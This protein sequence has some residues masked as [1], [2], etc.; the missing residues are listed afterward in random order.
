MLNM[1][2]MRFVGVICTILVIL[3]PQQAQSEAFPADFTADTIISLN[4]LPVTAIKYGEGFNNKAIASTTIGKTEIERYRINSFKD[5]SA[6]IPNFY[7]PDYGSRMTS[8]IYVRGQGTRIDQPVVG[9]NI[10]NIPVLTKENYDL[11]LLDIERIEMLRG[12]QSALF[13]R[14]TM[15][16]V[17]NI[18]TLSPFNYQGTRAVLSYS[19]GNTYRI[20]LSTYQLINDR[21]GLSVAAGY[22]STDGFFDNNY[23]GCDLDWEKHGEG[24]AKLQWQAKEDLR[25]DNVFSFSIS[26]QGGYPYESAERGEINYND[27]CFYRRANI[28]DGITLELTRDRYTMTSITSYQY[29]DDNMT[30]DQ[31]FLPLSYF[32]LTQ[33]RREHTLTH[34]VMFKSP[35]ENSSPYS[36]L[37]GFFGFYKH[38]KMDAPV[39]FKDDGITNLIEYYRNLYNSDYPV[40]WDTRE[41]LLNSNFKTNNFGLALYH[42]S[43]YKL[44]RWTFTAALRLDFEY[45]RLDYLSQCNTGYNTYAPDGS[46]YRHDD[47]NINDPGNETKTFLQLLPKISASYDFDTPQPISVFASVGKGYKAGGFNTQMFSDVLQQRLMNYMGIGSNYKVEDIISYK[48]ETNWNI[49]AGVHAECFDGRI[50]TD[51]SLFY[52]HTTNQQLTMFPD[53][54][55]TGRIM[56]NAGKS[57]SYGAEIAIKANPIDPL[58]VSVSYGFT[59]ARF[60]EFNNG[61]ENYSGNFI[62]YAPQNTIFA[63]ANYVFNTHRS[64]L[65]SITLDA[66]LR[67]VGKIYWNETNDEKQPVYCLPGASV[68]FSNRNY[69]LELWG[70][71][72]SDTKYRTYYFTS[73]GHTFFQ[74]GK[75]I[76]IGATLRLNIKTI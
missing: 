16:G 58:S 10:D 47:V 26:R 7:I 64:W 59:D 38:M 40:S 63:S 33:K 61:L 65:R 72:L 12:P 11:D 24:R 76:T 50:R 13:G 68:T 49:E 45:N 35:K 2:N 22:F 74:R 69:S 44:G 1:H 73:I 52:I 57:R 46:L 27:T 18:T 31:D 17:I 48:P 19:S 36:W 9:M 34:D 39:T 53:G 5:A 20:G 51:V 28:S 43:A 66:H 56:T 3:A 71:N 23:N 75:P 4:E 8:S 67:A 54:N 14:N 21:V 15:A 70:E 32:T 29:L 42:Q 6:M 30:L 37:T 62:P 41:F 55:T 25:I 60:I